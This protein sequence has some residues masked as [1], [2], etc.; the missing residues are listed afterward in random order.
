MVAST[1]IRGPIA[2]KLKTLAASGT[3]A[4]SK[5]AIL[6]GFINAN[7]NQMELDKLRKIPF[8][9]SDLKALAVQ[10]LKSS[11]VEEKTTIHII[12]SEILSVA[13]EETPKNTSSGSM[14][15]EPL[16]DSAP[17]TP[18]PPSPSVPQPTPAIT[19]VADPKPSTL[20]NLLS[21]IQGKIEKVISCNVEIPAGD[22]S[23]LLS[24]AETRTEMAALLANNTNIIITRGKSLQDLSI[25]K[26]EIIGRLTTMRAYHESD[27][28]MSAISNV[29]V[30]K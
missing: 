30:S 9:E 8:S 5:A 7:L 14:S 22:I 25:L 2:I 19:P 20:K 26:L 27:T 23:R 4:A 15:L 18:P 13:T 16:P 28:L 3:A 21:E 6:K 10:I 24:D 1:T 17:A 12:D 11:E 29:M